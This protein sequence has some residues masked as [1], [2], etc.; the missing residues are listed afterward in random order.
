MVLDINHPG[1]PPSGVYL[2]LLLVL[3][4]L[5]A[6][7]Y[8]PGGE[9]ILTQAKPEKGFHYPYYLFIPDNTSTNHE[10][11]LIVEPNNSG[12]VSDKLDEHVEKAK[13]TA[14]MEFYTGNYV[15]RNLQYPLLV[16]AFPRNKTNNH[17]YTHSLD[18][19][20]LLEQG[21]PLERLDLQ[22]LA[23][24]QDARE[25]LT[26]MGYTAAE[27]FLMTGFSA[28][29][30]FANRFTALHPEKVKAVAA[31]GLNGLLMLPL[32]TINEQA[33][34]YPIGTSDFETLTGK[35]F[36]VD[37]FKKVPQF[38]F[39]GELD[40]NDAIPYSDAY[41]Q[42]EREIIYTLIASEEML[43]KRWDYCKKAYRNMGVNAEIKT[44]TK[45]GHDQPLQVKKDVVNFF[46]KEISKP[47]AKL[48]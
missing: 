23:M 31:G 24:T 14:T 26:E 35:E 8:K 45:T 39:M 10:V 27:Q 25:K 21:T 16:P 48:H 2:A 37:S 20:V 42:I 38:Y 5:P 34:I 44:Y 1:T 18:R 30:S 15:A 9:I 32:D 17:I 12:F 11:F 36:Q 4:L 7:I 43:P 28:S 47:E 29:G 41:S 6:C 13:R 46:K 40:E 33:L 3:L 19:D 22:L